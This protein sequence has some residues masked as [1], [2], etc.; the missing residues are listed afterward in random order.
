[1]AVDIV[2]E[3]K[4]IQVDHHKTAGGTRAHLG[5]FHACCTLVKES[6]KLIDRGFALQIVHLLGIRH[7]IVDPSKENIRIKRLSDKVRY[8]YLK[9][10]C[11]CINIL[12]CGEKNNRSLHKPSLLLKLTKLT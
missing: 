7:D 6:C 12:I 1:M 4:R 10:S 5:E 3:L 11:F 8:A 9:T 2:Y